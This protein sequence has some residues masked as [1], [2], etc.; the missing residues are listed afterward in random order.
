MTPAENYTSSQFAFT[1]LTER[2]VAFTVK[3]CS[4][5]E[6]ALTQIP[7]NLHHM[8]YIV[9]IGGKGNTVSGVMENG[10]WLYR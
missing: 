1:V 5:A 7:G 9:D 3:A 6:V 2:Q 4:D 10:N 8:A